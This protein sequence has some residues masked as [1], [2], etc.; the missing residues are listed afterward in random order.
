VLTASLRS[1]TELAFTA[2]SMKPVFLKS[3][4]GRSS[5]C[6][7][8]KRNTYHFLGVRYEDAFSFE[9]GGLRDKVS[10]DRVTFLRRPIVFADLPVVVTI[11]RS[12]RVPARKVG[13]VCT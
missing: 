3:K 4:V 13:S 8:G 6:A 11:G 9:D 2:R 12:G 10:D 5:L 7:A 1:S